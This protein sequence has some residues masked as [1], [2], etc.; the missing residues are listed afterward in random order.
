MKVLLK[1][2]WFMPCLNLLSYSIWSKKVHMFF[3]HFFDIFWTFSK[4]YH[5]NDIRVICM[6]NNLTVSSRP[7]KWR[8]WYNLL[9]PINHSI[10]QCCILCIGILLLV[11]C[12]I[13]L[14][15]VQFL[16]HF[17]Q[18]CNFCPKLCDTFQVRLHMI[19]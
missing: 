1:K 12:I 3:T 5:Y 14:T 11:N 8:V 4:V 19:A 17:Q 2:K 13:F 10:Y 18:L 16:G 9:V 6:C 15:I 7:K